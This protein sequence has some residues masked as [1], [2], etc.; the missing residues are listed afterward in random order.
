MEYADLSDR[1]VQEISKIIVGREEVIKVLLVSLLSQGHIL[2]EGNPGM[3]KTSVAKAFS[4]TIGGEFSRIQMTPDTLPADILGTMVYDQRDREFSFHRGPIFGNVILVDEL[5]RATP[6]AQSALLEAMQERQVSYEGETV[7]LGEP[8]MVIATQIPYG[9]PGT[10]P[11]SEVQSDRFAYSLHL[12]DL[13]LKEEMSVLERIDAIESQTCEQ[14]LDPR[15][16]TSQIELARKVFV[17]EPVEEYIVALRDYIRK[18]S[19]L[20][21]APSVRASIALHKGSRAMALLE[22]RDH[23]IPDDVKFLAPFVFAHRI[24]LTAEA[25]ADEVAPQ[26]IVSEA[27]EKTPVPK[28]E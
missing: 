11:L 23:V 24:F 8:F 28:G 27:L 10:Y 15:Q 3:G 18:S 4:Q 2:L 9:S 21:A 19:N 17:S 26:M 1:F 22:N 16:A 12:R 7:K 13:V 14:L 25:V 5:N 20:K 6:K